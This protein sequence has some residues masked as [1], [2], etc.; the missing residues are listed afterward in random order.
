MKKLLAVCLSL[1]LC[2]ASVATFAAKA[3]T[4]AS[5]TNSYVRIKTS[6]NQNRPT[7]LN[8]VLL[9]VQKTSSG[10]LE[11]V[12]FIPHLSSPAFLGDA[13]TV[14]NNGYTYYLYRQDADNKWRYCTMTFSDN[15]GTPSINTNKTCKAAPIL[16]PGNQSDYYTVTIAA[17]P[18]TYTAVGGTTPPVPAPVVVDPT[19]PRLFTFVNKTQ[20][21]VIAVAQ[22]AGSNSCAA[23][24]GGLC[25]DHVLAQG[26]SYSFDQ[27]TKDN[28]Y[29]APSQAYVI[30][31]YSTVANCT[32]KQNC[33]ITSSGYEAKKSNPSAYGSKFEVTWQPVVAPSSN[34]AARVFSSSNVDMSAADGVSF[35]AVMSP[36]NLLFPN[37]GTYCT[38]ETPQKVGLYDA[39]HP[40]SVVGGSYTG[41]DG[42]I[43]NSAEGLCLYLSSQPFFP[44][45]T[46][47]PKQTADLMI[48]KQ[49][50]GVSVFSGCKAP[51]HWATDN[52][53]LSTLYFGKDSPDKFQCAGDYADATACNAAGF[54]NHTTYHDVIYTAFTNVYAYP[55]DD[56]HADFGC[57]A[58]TSYTINIVSTYKGDNA[59]LSEA[60]SVEASSITD[61]SAIISWTAP[62]D[63]DSK[64]GA[65]AYRV[66]ALSAT[67]GA[68][69][70]QK[71]DKLSTTLMG[72][73]SGDQYSVTVTADDQNNNESTSV[74]INITVNGLTAPSNLTISNVEAP[75][76]T[77]LLTWT[78]STDTP[79]NG[80]ITYTAAIENLST[81]V[82]GTQT[83]TEASVMLTNLT[84][85]T[86]YA[87]T[88]SGKDAAGNQSPSSLPVQFTEWNLTA[89]TNVVATPATAND[90]VTSAKVSWDPSS[91]DAPNSALIYTVSAASTPG[92]QPSSQA[93]GTSPLELGG[94]QTGR[95]YY[96]TVTATDGSFGGYAISAPPVIVP[97]PN[98]YTIT[99]PSGVNASH[100]DKT[101]MQ[102]N[103]IASTDQAP[104][105]QIGYMVWASVNPDP[106]D[107]SGNHAA[108]H[109]SGGAS[110]LTLYS[111]KPGTT[112]YVYVAANDQ[113]SDYAEAA[114]IQVQTNPSAYTFTIT[115]PAASDVG[116]TTADISWTA[117]DTDKNINPANTVYSVIA[118]P[119]N[120]APLPAQTVTGVTSLKLKDLT[121]G[122]T[123]T[124]IVKGVDSDK[125]TAASLPSNP[126]T[127]TPT[128]PPQYQLTITQP[129]ASDVGQTT[130]DISWT[131]ADTDKNINPENTVYS[132]IATPQGGSPLPAQTV[133]GVTSLKLKDL[134]ASTPYTVVVTG[135][136][137]AGN[138]G[139]SPS[140]SFNTLAPTYNFTIGGVTASHV[141]Q[142]TATIDWLSSDNDPKAKPIT[143]SVI[144]TPQGGS[145]L[146][147]QT[148][149]GATS[150]Q[151][152]DLTAGTTYT[153]IVKGV[154]SDK[155][156]AASLPSL[157]FSTLAPTYTLSPA[158]A[159]TVP[160]ASITQTGATVTWTAAV[161]SDQHATINYT[162][163]LTSP[164]GTVTKLPGGVCTASGC[165]LNLTGL[166]AGQNYSVVVEATDNHKN[167]V[168]SASKVP[169][170]TLAPTYT[171]QPA[172]D[173]TVPP[174]SI[175]QTGATVTWT[176][177]V[178][179]DTKAT[180]N[181]TVNL[182]SPDGTVTKLPGGV[183][184]ASGCSLNLTG[185]TAGQNY[186]VVVEA[187][188]NHKNDV[189]SA[190]KVPFTTAAS[191]PSYKNI[192]VSANGA[193]VNSVSATW[194][195]VSGYNLNLYKGVARGPDGSIA[196]HGIDLSGGDR[197]FTMRFIGLH[198]GIQYTIT[199]TAYDANNNIVAQGET[200]ITPY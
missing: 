59:P 135:V 103:W 100:V 194:D 1:L 96:I 61:N 21:P 76:G 69:V 95:T 129:A 155:N 189:T 2:V 178:D 13:N 137:T 73:T 157:P 101:S 143:Y 93:A 26:D 153:V 94:L 146:P 106:N 197:K 198:T 39:S 49:V 4:A 141:G 16:D 98:Q 30:S 38:Y 130:A 91:D 196:A 37:Q 180:I 107:P 77:A 44:N 105:P 150:L 67:G 124:V 50:N 123:Y 6:I 162:V 114:P 15:G 127:T 175:T 57:P 134:T 51:T 145:P 27:D 136:D 46:I 81:G 190:S 104:A 154:D 164:G 111:L 41:K 170:T 165:S 187:T 195:K 174:A 63:S 167:D 173:V 64:G 156:T 191:P 92:G 125:N 169:F 186:S 23:V 149:T 72:L 48:Y 29:G 172:T 5:D 28:M 110:P 7:G 70:V 99:A 86:S 128:P 151:L 133:T 11:Q 17:D 140:G 171:L 97:I 10:P 71:T 42:S 160:P 117:A 182:T 40:I 19:T 158:T 20:Y 18:W 14:F 82:I 12:A 148:V 54:A 66:T 144:A 200:N 119:Q 181:Y 184:T 36:T 126:F 166:T 53:L 34:P 83:S 43:Y 62:A 122:T 163:N 152:K 188:D 147:A 79:P 60:Q 112:Y 65:I 78:P 32:P 132:V 35:G 74:P 75:N 56:N 68:P 89:P 109:S 168:T 193:G 115:Q 185:L 138:K 113:Y 3:T 177:A 87:V 52:P 131:A 90:G 179:S 25:E 120:G 9:Y 80:I 47:S 8:P 84:K 161:D 85:D 108:A 33:W 31:G 58:M 139:T 116:Q 24:N 88:V 183:C 199:I 45:S 192:V 176:A 102:I 22:I 118:T 159:V 55:Y 142:K 121:A